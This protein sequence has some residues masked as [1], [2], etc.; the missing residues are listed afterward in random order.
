MARNKDHELA[1]QVLN[2]IIDLA[3]SG[4]AVHISDD[5]FEELTVHVGPDPL[6]HCHISGDGSRSGLIE[7]L[8]AA[9]D[10]GSQNLPS[11]D[12]KT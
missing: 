4:I 6:N 9:I 10:S 3:K 2:K 8:G 7:A 5:S 1:L 12:H 11:E